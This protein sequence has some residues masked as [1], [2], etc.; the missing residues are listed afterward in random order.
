MRDNPVVT[1]TVPGPEYLVTRH[2]IRG[3]SVARLMLP[4]TMDVQHIVERGRELVEKAKYVV[5]S[6]D[7]TGTSVLSEKHVDVLE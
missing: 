3:L 4:S 1:Y 5:G 6:P 7:E 2:S